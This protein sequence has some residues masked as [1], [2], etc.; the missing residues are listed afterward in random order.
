MP[1]AIKKMGRA[2]APNF[3][4]NL[5]NASP[6]KKSTLPILV[7]IVLGGAAVIWYFYTKS[8]SAANTAGSSTG[9]AVTVGAGASGS[10]V[11]QSSI[12]N[13]TQAVLAMQGQVANNSST[14][15]G[16]PSTP[17]TATPSQSNSGNTSYSGDY[18]AGSGANYDT[19][20]ISPNPAAPV[21]AD[22]VTAFVN[23]NPNL[24]AT[25]AQSIA[26]ALGQAGWSAQGL[27]SLQGLSLSKIIPGL[28]V[29]Q[30]GNP[31]YAT[32]SLKT[33]TILST[34]SL[35][36]YV[37]GS[38]PLP[39]Q[40]TTAPGASMGHVTTALGSILTP[41]GSTPLTVITP[42]SDVKVGAV[43]TKFTV[44]STTSQSTLNAKIAQ[45]AAAHPNATQA[46]IIATAKKDLG[47]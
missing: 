19:G 39:A 5:S 9:S 1:P 28:V 22:L 33:G 18:V 26:V 20:A 24:S 12:D 23:A 37:A 15:A 42:G 17:V 35:G 27:A 10:G 13:L 34:G 44:P 31:V 8:N 6:V 16:G 7:L 25:Q 14:P 30:S 36:T 29:D 2:K 43:G 11:D 3:V 47:M 46:S 32:Q 41:T 45:V 38:Y 40:G 21:R 4:D